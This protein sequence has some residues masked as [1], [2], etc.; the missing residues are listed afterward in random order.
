M[1]S[2]NLDFIR[3]AFRIAGVEYGKRISPYWENVNR[4]LYEI[5][6]KTVSGHI[7]VSKD[8]NKLQILSGIDNRTKAYKACYNMS[9]LYESEGDINNAQIWINRA[10]RKKHNIHARNYN[11]ILQNR[12][13]ILEILNKQT[14]QRN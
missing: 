5:R 11:K 13:K 3:E 2:N 12:Q 7:S 1:F 14:G 4:S 8:R 6:E 10:M 9:V